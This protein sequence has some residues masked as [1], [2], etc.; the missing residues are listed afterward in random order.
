MGELP[1]NLYYDRLSKKSSRGEGSGLT[2]RQ[3]LPNGEDGSFLLRYYP[4]SSRKRYSYY[5]VSDGV[6][7][8][9]R[10]IEAPATEL[11]AD[12]DVPLTS[13]LEQLRNAGLLTDRA[14]R[15]A[16]PGV[17]TERYDPKIAAMERRAGVANEP[18]I[19]GRLFGLLAPVADLAVAWDL[20]R[21]FEQYAWEMQAMMGI[22]TPQRPPLA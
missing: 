8:I 2:I 17:G 10:A 22:P 12:A 16:S 18:M 13:V 15:S 1:E 20:S 19:N 4:N 21:H 6:N 5:R 9:S 7:N 3:R 11:F 14:V